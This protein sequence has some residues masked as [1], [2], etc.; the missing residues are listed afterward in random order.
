MTAIKWVSAIV[1]VG[2]LVSCSPTNVL[3]ISAQWRL[4]LEDNESC[5][6]PEFDDSNWAIVSIPGNFFKEQKKQRVWVHSA[7]VSA[8]K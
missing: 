7:G 1:V 4:S 8:G 2:A 6:N 3:D 5:A